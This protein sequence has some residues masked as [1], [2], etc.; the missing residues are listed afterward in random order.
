MLSILKNN[1]FESSSLFPRFFLVWSELMAFSCFTKKGMLCRLK[2]CG[3]H[4]IRLFGSPT[5]CF[6]MLLRGVRQP[7]NAQVHQLHRAHE[8]LFQTTPRHWIKNK[9]GEKK[10]NTFSRE[11]E[12]NKNLKDKS[13]DKK[14]TVVA[15]L[16]PCRIQPSLSVRKK[17]LTSVQKGTSGNNFFL[18]FRL[19][20]FISG[21]FGKL[22]IHAKIN[23]VFQG[24]IINPKI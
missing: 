21:T 2:K 5:V 15:Y 4:H 8:H 13:D 9:K 14:F 12:K 17:N 22:Q 23:G 18:E 11:F 10:E 19:R 6:S 1:C 20:N 24:K 16:L 7:P 3:Y